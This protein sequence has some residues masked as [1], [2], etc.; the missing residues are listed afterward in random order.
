MARKVVHRSDWDDPTETNICGAASFIYIL[1]WKILFSFT[2]I[3]NIILIQ[4]YL[5]S[6]I[7]FGNKNN[8][9]KQK[10]CTRVSN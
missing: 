9:K 10:N 5:E 6:L 4:K 1:I 3:E 7:G 2:K 8:L